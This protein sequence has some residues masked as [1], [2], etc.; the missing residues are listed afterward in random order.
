MTKLIAALLLSLS[1]LGTI[2]YLSPLSFWQGGGW[3]GPTGWGA[4]TTHSFK[5][6]EINSTS[7]SGALTLLLGSVVVLRSRV[8]TKR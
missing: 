4:P 1:S 6:P 3:G 5:A 8:A 2:A 7:A